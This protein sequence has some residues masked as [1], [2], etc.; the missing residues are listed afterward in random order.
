MV[1]VQLDLVLLYCIAEHEEKDAFLNL[2]YLSPS[3]LLNV[4]K[5]QAMSQ[6]ISLINTLYF[7]IA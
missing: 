7:R 6:T 1:C 2:A 4:L 5:T 3:F